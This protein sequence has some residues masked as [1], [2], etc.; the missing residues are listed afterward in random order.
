L[1]KAV[2]LY[3]LKRYAHWYTLLCWLLGLS[4]FA[5]FVSILLVSRNN[6]TVDFARCLL[7][8]PLV[9][10]LVGYNMVVPQ[11]A[12]S[13]LRKDGEYL[14]LLFTR[15]LSRCSYVIT[16]WASGMLAI[17]VV[18][19]LLTAMTYGILFLVQIV[20]QQAAPE[21]LLDG[22]AVVDALCNAIGY[23]ALMILISSIPHP[24]GRITLMLVIWSA[25]FASSTMS[26][27]SSLADY[28]ALTDVARPLSALAQITV[29]VFGV[30]IDSYHI[31]NSGAFPLSNAVIFVSNVVLY[32]TLSVFIMS[33]REFFY[34]N[35]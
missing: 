35:D 24:W 14:S 1:N 13:Q 34:A 29:S 33:L 25:M 12:N 5:F 18:T 2:L 16:K 28:L 30:S 19:I 27:I 4:S 20:F 6:V 7:F 17:V 31:V 3:T 21:N 10:I 15:P 8:G 26:A 22:Y 9:P 32:L 23:S 11:V